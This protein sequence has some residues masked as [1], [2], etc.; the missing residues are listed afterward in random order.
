MIDKNI[1]LRDYTKLKQLALKNAE[2]KRFDNAVFY[3]KRAAILMYNSNIIYTD[4]VLESLLQNISEQIITHRGP[5]QQQTKRIVFYDY[6]VLDNR[7]L[8]EQYLDALFSFD[9]EVLFIGCQS[10]EKSKEIYSKLQSH[11]VAYKYISECDEIT[12][13]ITIYKLISDF[14]P[15]IILAHTAPWDV[16]GL[17]AINRCGE[18]CKR[19]LINITDHAFWL[20]STV[21]DYFLE[22]R[23]YGYNISKT[24]RN[25]DEKRLLKLPYY[26]IINKN[27]EFEGFHFNTEGKKLI[28]SGGS[29]YKIQGSHAF[30][31]IIKYIITKYPETI[32]LFLGNGDSKYLLDFIEQNN[33]QERVFYSPE[34]KDIYEVFRH[35]D[36]YLNTYPLIGALMTQY[37][38]IAG[39]LPL[40]LNDKKDPCNGISELMID[41]KNIELEF[42]N[43][44]L[45]KSKLDLYLT[46]DEVLASDSDKIK[47][48]IIS[49]ETFNNILLEYIQ[50]DFPTTKITFK[51]YDIDIDK[52]AEQYIT[53]FNG[54]NG[55]TYY[56]LFIDR[57]LKTLKSFPH[58]Y[59]KYAKN[60]IIKR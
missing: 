27:I 1:I 33:F 25:I 22:F 47:K 50:E 2:K 19:F 8:T 37:A 45:L 3:L 54:H 18:K 38:C 13:A 58:Y 53:R 49:P 43:M 42:D 17:M 5:K 16:A 7:G 34:R 60:R 6:F 51:C 57:S 32:F 24:F 52:F 15:Q 35:C 36:L 41:C 4:E 12:K 11:N 48:A 10:G 56:K 26:P 59:V 29:I 23:N 31:D 55:L 40:T 14:S 44:D 30:L 21:F 9:Y 20:G 46:N 39:K 28:F